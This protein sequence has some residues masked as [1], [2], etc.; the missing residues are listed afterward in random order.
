[1]G[2]INTKTENGCKE[3]DVRVT[4]EIDHRADFIK[5]PSAMKRFGLTAEFL[6]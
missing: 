4:Y 5:S 2:K 6:D 3:V 1:M